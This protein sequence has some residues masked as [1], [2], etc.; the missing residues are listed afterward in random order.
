MLVLYKMLKK[1]IIVLFGF[2]FSTFAMVIDTP[3]TTQLGGNLIQAG[4][5]VITIAS[6]NVILD[7]GENAVAGGINGIKINPNLSNITIRNGGITSV[8]NA[9]ISVG[10]N[11]SSITLQKLKLTNCVKRG[12]EFLG[13]STTNDISE[14][15]IDG[16]RIETSALSPLSDSVIFFQYVKNLMVLGLQLVNNGNSLANISLLKFNNSTE[17]LGQVIFAI[18]NRGNSLNGVEFINPVNC[19]IRDSIIANNDATLNCIGVKLTGISTGNAFRRISIF[20]NTAGGVSTGFDLSDNSESNIISDCQVAELTGGSTYGYAMHGNNSTKNVIEKSSAVNLESNQASGVA[21]GIYVD[22]ATAGTIAESIASY[23]SALSGTAYGILFDPINGGTHW[24]I[25]E[26][27]IVRNQ[28]NANNS[29]FGINVQGGSDNLFIKN[30]AY[31]NGNIP[32]NQMSGVPFGSV[33]QLNVKNL[34]SAPTPWANVIII[35]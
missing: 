21:V 6:S 29:S 9:G 19:V 34:N 18:T 26:N 20:N 25:T 16:V 2:S 5:D 11:C 10:E 17:C 4:V 33:A 35:P 28:G 31:D 7:L 22:G 8:T 3:G 32:G 27:K 30:F 13:T 1:F 15:T 14:I 12:M 23:N 24:N